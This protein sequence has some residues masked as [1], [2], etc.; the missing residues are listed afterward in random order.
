MYTIHC[1][2]YQHTVC[3]LDQVNCVKMYILFEVIDFCS[4]LI[5]IRLDKHTIVKFDFVSLDK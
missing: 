5:C 3:I 2:S 4:L 1:I